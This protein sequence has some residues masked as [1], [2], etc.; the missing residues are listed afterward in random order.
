MSEL[1]EMDFSDETNETLAQVI[2]LLSAEVAEK[3]N[4][5]KAAKRE[6]ARRY[7]AMGAAAKAPTLNNG[8]RLGI[9]PTVRFDAPT[10]AANLSAAKLKVISAMTAQ[11]GLAKQLLSPVEYKKTQKTYGL[12]ITVTMPEVKE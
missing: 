3:E 9:R 6:L 11:S 10:A 2:F 8:L 5:V 4:Q 12:T 7:E 1:S